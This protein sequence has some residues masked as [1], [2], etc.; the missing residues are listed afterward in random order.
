M[1]SLLGGLGGECL[2]GGK[3]DLDGLGRGEA[4]PP[5]SSYQ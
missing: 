4:D 2:A 5:R 1:V 3:G